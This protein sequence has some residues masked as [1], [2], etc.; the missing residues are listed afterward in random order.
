MPYIPI[1]PP[2]RRPMGELTDEKRE[3]LRELEEWLA[4]YPE[5]EEFQFPNGIMRERE[6]FLDLID[7]VRII[8]GY[9]PTDRVWLDL[10]TQ[11]HSKWKKNKVC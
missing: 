8:E 11:A 10:I 5:G 7:K 3:Y 4:T 9:S 6:F 2:I 1:P